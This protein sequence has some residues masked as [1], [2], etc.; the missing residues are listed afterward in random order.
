MPP[1]QP[2]PPPGRPIPF[3]IALAP[4]NVPV[5]VDPVIIDPTEIN[6]V[7][8]LIR[9]LEEELLPVPVPPP[10]PLPP[11]GGTRRY[12]CLS[13]TLTSPRD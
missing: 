10:L 5:Q 6:A 1:A 8:E 3:E 11:V 2:I 7:E 9:E 4:A 12:R 13:Y